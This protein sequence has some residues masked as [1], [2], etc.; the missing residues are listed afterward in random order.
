MGPDSMRRMAIMCIQQSQEMLRT[1]A[2][3]AEFA[4]EFADEA[5]R[6]ERLE[7]DPQAFESDSENYINV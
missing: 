4:N 1:S 7:R 3:Y 5:D 6:R 2:K